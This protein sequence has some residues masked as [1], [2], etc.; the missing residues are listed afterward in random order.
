MKK[1]VIAFLLIASFTACTEGVK[2][3]KATRKAAAKDTRNPKDDIEV[4]I[5]R[6]GDSMMQAFKNKD[7]TT[8]AKYNHPAM[9]A[10]MGGEEAFVGLLA[11]QMQQIPDSSIK[12][13]K[14]GKV[15]QVI[16]TPYDHQCVV[17]QNMEM[18]MESM[19]VNS[20]TYLVG[21]SLNGG[22]NWTFFD[23]SNSERIKATDIK[24]NL[25]REIIVPEKKQEMKQL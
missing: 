10:M 6:S 21:E 4:N 19:Q 13:I 12:L 15:L 14:I 18:V 16:K 23:A 5:Y 22:K 1:I 8:F 17:E 11:N 9:L 24:P 7:W 25:S 20:T 3:G 2:D